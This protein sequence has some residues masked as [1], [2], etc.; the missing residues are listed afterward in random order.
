V[1]SRGVCLRGSNSLLV[2]AA[3]PSLLMAS[4]GASSFRGGRSLGMLECLR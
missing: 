2:T 1:R 3:R 4:R